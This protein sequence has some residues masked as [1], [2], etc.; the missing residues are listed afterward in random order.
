MAE[1]MGLQHLSLF[2]S[3]A[4]AALPHTNLGGG[5]PCFIPTFLG[6]FW[7]VM[8]SLKADVYLRQNSTHNFPELIA[9]TTSAARYRL[10]EVQISGC[11]APIL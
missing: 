4:L 11:G 9:V 1:Q 6:H 2:V 10:P 5:G 8:N 3:F 7:L